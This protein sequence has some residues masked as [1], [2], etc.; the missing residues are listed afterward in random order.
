MEHPPVTAG[1]QRRIMY[2][3]RKNDSGKAEQENQ[4]PFLI[5]GLH[6]AF[7]FVFFQPVAR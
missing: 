7:C 4:P 3:R 2:I 6:P 1:G 5:Y